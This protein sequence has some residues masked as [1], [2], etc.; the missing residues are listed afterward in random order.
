VDVKS[1]AADNNIDCMSIGKASLTATSVDSNV[2]LSDASVSAM[3]DADHTSLQES[4]GTDDVMGV[5]TVPSEGLVPTLVAATPK[6]VDSTAGPIKLVSSV[7]PKSSTSIQVPLSARE[8]SHPTLLVGPAVTTPSSRRMV[9]VLPAG[10]RSPSQVPTAVINA[11]PLTAA[12]PTVSFAAQSPSKVTVLSLPKTSSVPG[13]F[14]TI[15]PSS[16]SASAVSDNKTTAVPYKVLI[17][18]PSAVS[19]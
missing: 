18:P 6:V 5:V 13:Q 16:S 12:S 9:T 10:I 2:E 7:V 1:E 8:T 14:V 15:I 11:R 3:F 4:S 19:V 17:R